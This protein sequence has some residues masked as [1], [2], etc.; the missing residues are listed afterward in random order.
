MKTKLNK[1]KQSWKALFVLLITCAL[2][3]CNDP[4]EDSVYRTSD[5]LMIDEYM[6]QN[7]LTDFLSIIDKADYRGMLHAY[8]TYTCFVPTNEA[9]GKYLKEVGKTIDGLSKEEAMN[10]VGYHVVNDTLATTDFVDGRLA[11]ANIAKQYIVTRT[12]ADVHNNVYIELDRKAKII[13]KDIKLGNGYIHVLDAMLG[14]SGKTVAENIQALPDRF[15]FLKDLFSE[16]GAYEKL[17]YQSVEKEE[18]PNYYTVFIQDNQTF[19]DLGIENRSKLLER[20]RANSPEVNNDDELIR[21]FVLYHVIDGRRY[22]NDLMTA[23]ALNTLV[24]QQVL[25]FSMT[26]DVLLINEYKIGQ[27]NEEGVPV[28]R[29]SEYSDVSCANGVMHEVKGLLEIKKRAAYRVN[30]DF[31]E[32]PEMKALKTFRKAGSKAVYAV[33]ELSE[34]TFGG[35]NNPSIT[36]VCDG[37]SYGEKN[38]YIYGDYLM[39]RICTNV[40]QWCEFKLPLLVEGTYKVWLCYRRNN[41]MTFRSTFKQEGEEDQILPTVVDMS[42]YMPISYT[43]ASKTTVDHDKMEQEGWKQYTARKENSVMNSRLM[44]TIKVS[45]TGRHTLRMDALSGSKG[46]GGNWDMIQFIPIDDDQIWP[47][48]DML[49]TSIEK[50]TTLENIWPY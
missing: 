28:D 29:E 8:G 13:K 47:M 2:G 49:G 38:Q 33:N 5:V 40:M 37:T 21:N 16:S 27:L 35:K 6:E 10:I 36:Y 43:D 9:I 26:K 4:L 48:L 25:S 15:S 19:I 1:I 41:P 31:G 46:T 30:F 12:M 50:N 20:L 7:Q 44:G 3:A 18:A 34:I 22:I 24:S 42:G 23:S 45:S 14:K 11:S 32:Q 17:G 39:F